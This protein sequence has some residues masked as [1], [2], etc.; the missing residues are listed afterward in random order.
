[1]IQHKKLKR[2]RYVEEIDKLNTWAK[3]KPNEKL[4][5]RR[6]DITPVPKPRMTK[7]DKWKKR[8]GVMRYWAFKDQVKA[9]KLKL[10]KR[11]SHVVFCMPM[12]KSWSKK[13]K[14]EMVTMPHEQTPD[15]DNLLKALGDSVFSDDSGI[16]DI[17]AS[18]MWS[19]TGAI[20]IFEAK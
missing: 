9:A 5:Y 7:S 8:P 18:K 14:D 6:Y 16:S 4:K 1:M 15:L 3:N 13:K 11:G 17:R 10:P 12:P 20:V 19:E 2:K